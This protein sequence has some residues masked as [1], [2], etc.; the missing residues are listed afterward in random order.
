MAFDRRLASLQVHSN[1]RTLA[2]AL[3]FNLVLINASFARADVIFNVNTVADQIDLDVADGICQTST[4]A[5]SL[6]A[7][8]MQA[9]HLTGPIT[10]RIK[11]PVGTYTLTRPV[12]GGNGEDRGDL[13]N[14]RQPD[15]S[16]P[17]HRLGSGRDS[18]QG[19]CARR[20]QDR[21]ARWR[22]IQ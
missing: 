19:H 9:N 21:H 16:C 11:L 12:A 6:R 14:R 7:A 15:R 1:P 22:D 4:G 13:D 20:L 2:A 5:C 18:E 17:I 10:T 8:I 3:L